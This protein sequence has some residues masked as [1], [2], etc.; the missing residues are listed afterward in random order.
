MSKELVE[1]RFE[2]RELVERGDVL[3]LHRV[4]TGLH[5]DS[6]ELREVSPLGGLL[7]QDERGETLTRVG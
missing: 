1:D 6:I 2:N 5:R 7:P 4:M 3:G